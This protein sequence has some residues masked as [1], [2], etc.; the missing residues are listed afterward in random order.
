[1]KRKLTKPA[2]PADAR[3]TRA[4]LCASRTFR[5][6]RDLLGVLLE[7]KTYTHAEAWERIA[8]FQEGK[9]K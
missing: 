3:F 1:M 9:V 7:D 5:D 6:Y 4:Q 8:A 2:A